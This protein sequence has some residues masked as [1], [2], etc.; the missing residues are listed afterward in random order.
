MG[1]MAYVHLCSGLIALMNGMVH[2]SRLY[3]LFLKVDGLL[4]RKM[5]AREGVDVF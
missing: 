5:L 4:G 3:L 2:M 1:W